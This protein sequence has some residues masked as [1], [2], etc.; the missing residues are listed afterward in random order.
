M[1][2]CFLLIFLKLNKVEDT[3]FNIINLL[4]IPIKDHADNNG[5]L[6]ILHYVRSNDKRIVI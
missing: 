5:I 6:R 2:L 4:N 1:H 3:I